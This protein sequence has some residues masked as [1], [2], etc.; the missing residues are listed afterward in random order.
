MRGRCVSIVDRPRVPEVRAFRGVRYADAA[1]LKDLTCPPYDVIS[2]DEQRQLYERHPHNAVRLELPRSEGSDE[3]GRYASAATTFERWRSEGVL[4]RDDEPA[5]YVYRQDFRAGDG[6][7]RRVVGCIGALELEPFG[8]GVLPH[9]RTMPGPKKDRLA[10]MRACPVNVSP[11]FA[12]YRGMGGLAPFYDGLEGRPPAGRFQDDSGIL[13][14]LWVVDAPAE[15]DLLSG[16]IHEGPL[17]IAD[18]HHR[19]ETA[20]AYRAENEDH[21]DAH[22]IMC[23]CVDADSE[24]LVVLPYN[25]TVRSRSSQPDL[26]GRLA[27]W[28]ATPVEGDSEAALAASPFDHAFVFVTAA[29][30]VLVGASDADVVARTGE[31]HPAWLRLD[32]VALH[33]A[34]LPDV[35][36]EGIAD[37]SF[38]KDP[39]EVE[40]LVG[41]GG[42][43]AGVLLE[44]L[45]AADIVDVAQSGERMPQKAS[46]FWPKA[47]TG[48]VFRPLR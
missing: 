36:P 3:A 28:H 26:T 45:A 43:D 33:E 44:A 37:I 20:L 6:A 41:D 42:W 18:G 23:F 1:K 4:R 39:D 31:R 12:I 35:F 38:T 15:V 22:S 48:L 27:R 32:V 46:Y 13:H 24:E 19:Y 47:V 7:P 9:E 30:R 8:A 11:I 16:A 2:A 25:R 21:A 14:R 5:L 10:L 29:G 40:R 17:V 34:V